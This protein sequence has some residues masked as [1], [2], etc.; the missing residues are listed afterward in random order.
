MLLLI[1][2]VPVTLPVGA[3]VLDPKCCRISIRTVIG[4]DQP[5]LVNLPSIELMGF[6]LSSNQN[7]TNRK[8]MLMRFQLALYPPSCRALLVV[9]F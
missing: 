2:L 4:R 7:C 3:C 1:V 5:C 9:Q 8:G 6:N